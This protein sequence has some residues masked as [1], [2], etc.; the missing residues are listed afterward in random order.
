MFQK[1]LKNAELVI[2]NSLLKA[3]IKPADSQAVTPHPKSDIVKDR[4]KKISRN[5]P[6]PCG[7]VDPKTGKPIK[8]KRCCW[9]KYG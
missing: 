8:Y 6:C 3:N 7:K 4:R 1:L 9:P 2:V 5:D